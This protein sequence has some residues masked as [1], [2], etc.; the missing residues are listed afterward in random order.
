MLP[1]HHIIIGAIISLI[2]YLLTPI[3]IIQTLIIFLSSFLIDIDHYFYYVF[4]EKDFS[5]KRAYRYFIKIKQ[6]FK[7]ITKAQIKKYKLPL[8][9]FHGIEFYIL[10]IMLSFF[11]SFF[12]FILFGILIHIFFDYVE[13]LY[14]KEPFYSKFSQVYVYLTHKR[15]F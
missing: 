8:I 7:K 9:V 6:K 10:I 15:K 4:K 3:T 13:F 12:L 5:L 11:N 2:L 1:K 14:I